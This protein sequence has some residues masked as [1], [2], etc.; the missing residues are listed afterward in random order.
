MSNFG[1]IDERL[2]EIQSMLIGS[3]S[4]GQT[5]EPTP[6]PRTMPAP[7]TTPAQRT[8]PA[9]LSRFAQPLPLPPPPPAAPAPAPAIAVATVVAPNAGYP[10]TPSTVDLAERA[11]IAPA[12]AHA[13]ALIA[14]AELEA[15]RIVSDSRAAV[16][17]L[18]RQIDELVVLRDRLATSVAEYQRVL[19]AQA[20]PAAPAAQPEPW[21]VSPAG[22]QAL[23]DALMRLP[24]GG[25]AP[26]SPPFAPA[27]VSAYT[28]AAGD[29]GYSPS[30]APITPGS[31]GSAGGITTL[32]VGHFDDVGALERYDA[33]LSSLAVVQA[34]YLRAYDSGRAIFELTLG[35]PAPL[36]SE[37]QGL[38]PITISGETEGVLVASLSGRPL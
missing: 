17:K 1:L 32:I 7:R 14:S 26:G 34:I 36:V 27:P 15:A 19:A 21:T 20:Q 23:A 16:E 2:R 12:E 25:V 24:G 5:S 18:V 6:A 28:T 30:S 13:H 29:P 11:A 22:S 35:A 8:T 38:S 4:E 33:R 3:I 10:Q 9:P 37:L 31:F